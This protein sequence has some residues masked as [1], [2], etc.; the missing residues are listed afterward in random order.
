M[1]IEKPKMGRSGGI[2]SP[3]GVV[4]SRGVPEVL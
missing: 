1:G 3:I 4:K 2:M